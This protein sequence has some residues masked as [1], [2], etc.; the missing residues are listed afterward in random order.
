MPERA[1]RLSLGFM[2]VQSRTVV[3]GVWLLSAS[4]P[5]RPVAYLGFAP[6]LWLLLPVLIT[7]LT[8][9]ALSPPTNLYTAQYIRTNPVLATKLSPKY[10]TDDPSMACILHATLYVVLPLIPIPPHEVV[11]YLQ[12][13]RCPV[14]P[15]M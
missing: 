11:L 5:F 7:S 3:P 6:S 1:A 15:P 4:G 9:F 10:L 12:P 14:P 13:A 8:A 2:Y